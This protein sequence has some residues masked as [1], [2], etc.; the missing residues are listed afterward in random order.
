[1]GKDVL[2][3][4]NWSNTN[5]WGSDFKPVEGDSVFVPKG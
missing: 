3:V 2:Y 5:T 1:M 4:D